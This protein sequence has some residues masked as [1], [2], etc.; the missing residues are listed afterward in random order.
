MD[1]PKE[2]VCDLDAHH[3]SIC[4][5]PSEEGNYCFVEEVIR[6]LVP[7]GASVAEATHG[8]Q[9]TLP[10][11]SNSG[12]TL[13]LDAAVHGPALPVSLSVQVLKNGDLEQRC[14]LG[15]ATVYDKRL[16]DPPWVLV[17]TID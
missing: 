15:S 11:P 8:M 1:H 3:R 14:V 7:A 4:R 13:M 16:C 5:Y 10:S 17:C 12:S 6:E 2:I 9:E